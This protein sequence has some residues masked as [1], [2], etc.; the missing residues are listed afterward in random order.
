MIRLLQKR[1]FSH[2]TSIYHKFISRVRRRHVHCTYVCHVMHIPHPFIMHVSVS[3]HA[4]IWNYLDSYLFLRSIHF[5]A[6]YRKL[7][8]IFFILNIALRS[9]RRIKRTKV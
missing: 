9:I 8:E 2:R 3:T 6:S 7:Y 1:T 5:L 4:I